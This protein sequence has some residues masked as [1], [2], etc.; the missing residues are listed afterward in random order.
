MRGFAPHRLPRPVN[1]HQGLTWLKQAYN[2]P[3]GLVPTTSVNV[4]AAGRI[5]STRPQ[6]L[7]S[8]IYR[9][10]VALGEAAGDSQHLCSRSGVTVDALDPKELRDAL[11]AQDAV[12]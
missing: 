10:P 8:A 1:S 9:Q 2:I 11:K 5:I 12:V 3:I 6:A 4:L 7:A